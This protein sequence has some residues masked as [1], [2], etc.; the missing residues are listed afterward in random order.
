[1]K[2][3][4]EIT[5]LITC[6]YEELHRKLIDK[7]FEIKKEC[8]VEDEYMINKDIDINL[9]PKLEVLQKCILVREMIGIKKLLLYK[10]KKYAANGDILE[11]GKVSCPIMDTSK[12]T[13]FMK[14]INYK[15]LFK[16]YDKNIVY[17]NETTELTVQLVNDKYIFIEMEDECRHI[18]RK[19]NSIEEMKI[20][21]GSYDLPYSKDSYFVKK[22]LIMLEEILDK[23]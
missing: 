8:V 13:D 18:N 6:S 2:L 16:I 10:A 22:A 15:T 3:E 7:G 19:Y 21:L 5:V 1:M 9:L 4:K 14:A 23:K 12:A 20:D 17:A 11:E